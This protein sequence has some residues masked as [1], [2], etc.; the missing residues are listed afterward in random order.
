[1]LCRSA[2]RCW[3]VRSACGAA[4]S[5]TSI[6]RNRVSVRLTTNSTHPNM[7]SNVVARR[8]AAEQAPSASSTAG[9]TE[10][11]AGSGPKKYPKMWNLP[12]KEMALVFLVFSI[13]GSSAMV[14]VRRLLPIIAGWLNVPTEN[15]GVI[16][17]PWSYRLLYFAVMWPSYSLMLLI[18]GHLFGRGEYFTYFVKK[19]WAR[20]IPGPLKRKLLQ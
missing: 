13:T 4:A 7:A 19:M 6:W 1:M 15:S 14:V 2:L 8:K 10:S 3:P 12:P 17:G 18:I 20:F 16:N 11:A 9:S 5:P